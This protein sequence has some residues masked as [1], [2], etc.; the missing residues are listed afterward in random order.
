MT[1]DTLFLDR[2]ESIP[3]FKRETAV[4]TD[5]FDDAQLTAGPLFDS[6]PSLAL[7]QPLRGDMAVSALDPSDLRAVMAF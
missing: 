5:T 4:A 3:L 2:I 6:D 7:N 1:F